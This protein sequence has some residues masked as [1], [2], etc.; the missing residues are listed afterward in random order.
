MS[1]LQ[2][3]AEGWHRIIYKGVLKKKNIYISFKYIWKKEVPPCCRLILTSN[4]LIVK[5]KY[6]YFFSLTFPTIFH[7][8]TTLI[9]FKNWKFKRRIFLVSSDLNSNHIA[10]KKTRYRRLIFFLGGEV[11][12][13]S[14]FDDGIVFQLLSWIQIWNRECSTN[15]SWHWQRGVV[16]QGKGNW[17]PLRFLEFIHNLFNLFTIH[18]TNWVNTYICAMLSLIQ[19]PYI[20]VAVAVICTNIFNQSCDSW[21]I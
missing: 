8:F 19:A 4:I 13:C 5:D 15:P 1:T 17:K 3:S 7:F 11:F 14:I 9:K 18:K 10:V 16:N 12:Y 21:H 6:R 2:K 20:T